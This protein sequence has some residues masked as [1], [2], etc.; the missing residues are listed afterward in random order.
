MNP[1]AWI[2]TPI[3]LTT[4]KIEHKCVGSAKQG[5]LFRATRPGVSRAKGG[6][7]PV[8]REKAISGLA[9]ASIIQ[10]DYWTS[11]K[12]GVANSRKKKREGGGGAPGR[13]ATNH[14]GSYWPNR[15]NPRKKAQAKGGGKSQILQ[16]KRQEKNGGEAP[17][18]C[19]DVR[20]RKKEN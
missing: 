18:S 2:L 17:P 13:S 10:L 8:Q 20:R 4:N 7:E 5:T 19:V 16:S 3:W 9:R 14:S 6:R 12:R 11:Q 1:G 15:Y